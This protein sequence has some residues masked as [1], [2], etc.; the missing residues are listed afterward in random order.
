MTSRIC[1]LE[2]RFAARC[3][4]GKGSGKGSAPTLAFRVTE[5]Q[6][7]EGRLAWLGI[8]A[9]EGAGGPRAAMFQRHGNCVQMTGRI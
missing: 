9:G 4:Q 8:G 2:E 5:G 7:A 3:P 1:K 6:Q